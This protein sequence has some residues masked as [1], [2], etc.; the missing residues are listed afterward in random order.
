[1]EEG[2]PEEWWGG[3]ED[4]GSQG[5]LTGTPNGGTGEQGQSGPYV[6]PM[7]MM[8]PSNDEATWSMVLG[9][10]TWF[11]WISSPILCFTACV[12]PFSTIGGVILGHVGIRKASETNGLNKGMAIAGLIMN[13]LSVVMFVLAAAGFGLIGSFAFF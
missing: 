7:M 6:Q 11:S 5:V 10:V 2:R 13:Y 3:P 1:M 8:Q 9:I 12:V 4:S